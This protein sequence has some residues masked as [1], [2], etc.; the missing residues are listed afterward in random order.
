ML[1]LQSGVT[2]TVVD[3]CAG[4]AGGGTGPPFLL[5][6]TTRQ[7]VVR[8][9]TTPQNTEVEMRAA[10]RGT[11]LPSSALDQLDSVDDRER[12]KKEK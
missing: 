7:T 11:E 9:A 4:P 2:V 10:I 12:L 6:T 8:T 5:H 3:Q 1:Y